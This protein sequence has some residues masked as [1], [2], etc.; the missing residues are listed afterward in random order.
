MKTTFRMSASIA[1]LSLAIYTPFCSP[2]L[3]Q[4]VASAPDAIDQTAR[5]DPAPTAIEITPVIT[6]DQTAT[7]MLSDDALQILR[8]GQAIVLSNQTLTAI[9]NGNVLNGNYIAGQISLTDNALSNFN[10]MGNFVINTGAQN[11]LQSAMNV[12]INFAQ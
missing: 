12:T 1:M 10:G 5:V 8:G 4:D 6:E 7:D 3:A 11:N 9:A 2:A